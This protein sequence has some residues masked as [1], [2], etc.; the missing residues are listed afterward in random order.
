MA[1]S[2]EIAAHSAYD[3]F[4][5]YKYL[6]VNVAIFHLGFWR[7]NFFLI[8]PFPDHYLRLIKYIINMLLPRL[9]LST[10]IGKHNG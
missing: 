1:A 9:Y 3:I 5:L 7:G 4:S 2:W 6:I 8:V 10:E